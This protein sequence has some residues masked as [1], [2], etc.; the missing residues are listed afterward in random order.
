MNNKINFS[1]A[2][3]KNT[4]KRFTKHINFKSNKY[5]VDIVSHCKNNNLVELNPYG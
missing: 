3:L 5:F 4:K 1:I 2:D